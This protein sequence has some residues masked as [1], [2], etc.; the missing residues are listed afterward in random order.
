MT[1]GNGQCARPVPGPAQRPHPRIRPDRSGAYRFTARWSCGCGAGFG[2]GKARHGR[3]DLPAL[4]EPELRFAVIMETCLHGTS[5]R[6]VD[7]LVK[8]LGAD[9]GIRKSEVS[10]IS[11]ELDDRVVSLA[12]VVAVVVAADGIGRDGR[13]GGPPHIPPAQPGHVRD[14]PGT[15]AAMLGRQTPGA[16]AMPREA[17]ADVTALAA[18][19]VIRWEEDLAGPPAERLNKEIKRRTDVAGVF[20]NPEALLRLAGAVLAQAH[21]E[22]QVA[23]KHYLSEGSMTP[24]GTRQPTRKRQPYP[25]RSR[26]SQSQPAERS[27]WRSLTP[28]GGTRP[29]L[30]PPCC[31]LPRAGPNRGYVLQHITHTGSG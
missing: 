13:R 4:I 16:E 2:E 5:S 25:D 27:R 3:D 24:L 7:D 30:P 17:A 23:G 29:A 31:T 18:F 28:P 14:Q 12:V 9:L 22:W 11:S 21:D 1:C 15:I 6:K 10:R 19:P 26:H 8:A 20:P